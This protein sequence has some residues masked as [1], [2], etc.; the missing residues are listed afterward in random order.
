MATEDDQL[1]AVGGAARSAEHGVYKIKTALRA[2]GRS[3]QSP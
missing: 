1:M 3:A 2:A